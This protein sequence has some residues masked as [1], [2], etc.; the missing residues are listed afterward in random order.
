MVVGVFTVVVG[1]FTVVVGVFT[2]VVGVFTVVA[3]VSIV[4]VDKVDIDED[5]VVLVIHTEGVL[6]LSYIHIYCQFIFIIILPFL[7]T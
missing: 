1:A 5:E 7:H 3:V 4:V 2:V 6:T